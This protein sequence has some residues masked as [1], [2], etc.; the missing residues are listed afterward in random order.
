MEMKD[1]DKNMLTKRNAMRKSF[2]QENALVFYF[3]LFIYF[4]FLCTMP[5][6]VHAG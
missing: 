2:A 6:D 4:F 5:C 1:K 3:I